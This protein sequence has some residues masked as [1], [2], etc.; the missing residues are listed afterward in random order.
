VFI[1]PLQALEGFLLHC[2]LDSR[3]HLS[4]VLEVSL[5][6]LKHDPNFVDDM[7]DDESGDN[8]GDDEGDGDNDDDE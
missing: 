6:Y 7:E 5:K 4:T 3:A 1:V 2:P 8:D